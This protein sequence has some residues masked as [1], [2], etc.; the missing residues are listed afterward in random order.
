M[1]IYAVMQDSVSFYDSLQNWLAHHEIE[2]PEGD[3][4]YST[5]KG[6]H[7]REIKTT[8][9]RIIF[10]NDYVARKGGAKVGTWEISGTMA[11]SADAY[12]IR[13][14]LSMDS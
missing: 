11:D 7:L 3:V 14:D 8:D 13:P 9:E 6:L 2:M 1:H 4:V 12:L 5:P 10:G